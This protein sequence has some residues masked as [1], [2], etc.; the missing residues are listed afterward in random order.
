MTAALMLV[1]I[2]EPA[3]AERL[4][5]LLAEADLPQGW[6]ETA[7]DWVGGRAPYASAR[8]RVLGRRPRL[9]VEVLAT[10]EVAARLVAEIARRLPSVQVLRLPLLAAD[11]GG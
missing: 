8:E 1:L 11:P 5:D 7:T 9:R 4:S 10:A 3:Q 2:A 6:F